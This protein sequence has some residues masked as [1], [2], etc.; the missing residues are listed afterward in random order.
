MNNSPIYEVRAY[1]KPWTVD[2]Y[3]WPQYGRSE[4]IGFFHEKEEAQK[5]VE[6]NLCNIQDYSMQSAMIIEVAPGI[7]PIIIRSKC[8]YYRW[9]KREERF[10]ISKL[11]SNHINIFGDE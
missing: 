11:P 1:T 2:E 7:Y 6:E 5:A 10:E 3:G 9:N 8:L 4:R